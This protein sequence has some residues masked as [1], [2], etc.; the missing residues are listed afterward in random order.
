MKNFRL[1]KDTKEHYTSLAELRK[2]W[3]RKPI[4]KL[5][6]NDE[7][8]L[9]EQQENF[10]SKHKC[11]A[12]GEPMVWIGGSM[13]ACKNENCKGI[14]VEE[15]DKDGNI[16]RIEYLVSY[17]LLDKKGALIAENIFS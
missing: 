8:K 10:C 6:T 13:M 5:R 4:K 7:K 3:G 12:C 2:A 11:K 9:K 14:K 16:I 17:E 15:K 1:G